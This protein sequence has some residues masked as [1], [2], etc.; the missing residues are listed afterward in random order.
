MNVCGKVR[1]KDRKW[2]SSPEGN[3]TLGTLEGAR[4]TLWEARVELA[5]TYPDGAQMLGEE[6][7]EISGHYALRPEHRKRMCSIRRTANWSGGFGRV[8]GALM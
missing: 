5:E 8:V 1:R 2:V 7:E 3:I 6:G 4:R